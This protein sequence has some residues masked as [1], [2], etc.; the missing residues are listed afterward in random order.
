MPITVEKKLAAIDILRKENIFVMDDMRAMRQDIRPLSM[1]VVNLMPKKA[2]TEVHILRHLANTPLQLKVD[3][4]YMANHEAKNTAMDYLKNFYKTF[5]DVKDSFYD[6]MIITGA[7]VETL[8]YEDVDY[9][10]EISRLFDWSKTHV[11]ST[12]HFCWGAQAGLYYRYGIQK[13]RLPKKL[14]GIYTQE[15]IL[16]ENPLMRGFDD[17]FKAPHSRYTEVTA[18]EVLE[19]SSLNILAAGPEV[20]L[21]ILASDDL[22]QVYNFGHLEYTRNTLA[23][24]YERDVKAGKNPALPVNYYPND[25]P[26]SAP[27]K[28]WSLAAS[29]FFSNWVNA[30]YQETPYDLTEL[31]K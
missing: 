2:N 23:E 12:M 24:E 30:V 9:W 21:S 5:E 18:S 11:F 31:S 20:G 14:S 26:Q 27:K 22:R 13:Y 8:E 25:D 15:V 6:G 3:F 29:V 1:L 19:K 10:E 17:E 16:R 4:L 7:P 28:T